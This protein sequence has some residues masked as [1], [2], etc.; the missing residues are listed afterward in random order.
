MLQCFELSVLGIRLLGVQWLWLNN[1]NNN[2]Q[3]SVQE[4]LFPN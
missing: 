3:K 4:V 1:N 2:D